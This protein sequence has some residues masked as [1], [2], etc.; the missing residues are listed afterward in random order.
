MFC[1]VVFNSRIY[2]GLVVMRV[3]IDAHMGEGGMRPLEGVFNVS[4]LERMLNYA[5]LPHLNL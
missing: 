2:T 5:I 1:F 4:T 3:S